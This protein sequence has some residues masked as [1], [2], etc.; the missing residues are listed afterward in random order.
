MVY[1]ATEGVDNIVVASI[2]AEIFDI[3]INIAGTEVIVD[4]QDET[5]V[6]DV[7]I[8]VTPAAWVTRASPLVGG[9]SKARKIAA[10][11]ME[12]IMQAA[13]FLIWHQRCEVMVKQERLVG[14]TK[15]A[16]CAAR[17]GRAGAPRKK[18]K[19]PRPKW[20]DKQRAM[21]GVSCA[22]GYAQDE[23]GDENQCPVE[24]TTQAAGWDFYFS[25]VMGV[26]S[27]N[28]CLEGGVWSKL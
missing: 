28:Y 24:G 8:G 1:Q 22:C 19:V 5:E 9:I 15:K 13:H 11:I 16:K 26:R 7:L 2:A 14:I 21:A 17:S 18:R 6:G 25:R 3:Q 10:E 23:H 27:R 4:G 20:T 12:Q